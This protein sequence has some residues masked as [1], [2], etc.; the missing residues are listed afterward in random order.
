M[1]ARY[2]RVVPSEVG[3]TAPDPGWYPCWIFI[4][5]G[6]NDFPTPL[7]PGEIG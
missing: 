3:A 2:T 5:L 1:P 4:F 7:Q 6:I